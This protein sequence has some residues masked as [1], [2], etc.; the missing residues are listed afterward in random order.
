MGHHLEGPQVR[1]IVCQ[2]STL[3]GTVIVLHWPGMTGKCQSLVV[4]Q[5]VW[6]VLSKF[7]CEEALQGED[8]SQFWSNFI[9]NGSE[10]ED[11]KLKN[12]SVALYWQTNRRTSGSTSPGQEVQQGELR[13]GTCEAAC[14][15][16]MVTGFLWPQRAK[17]VL[18]LPAIDWRVPPAL[19]K[20][21]RCSNWAQRLW[22]CGPQ[23]RRLLCHLNWLWGF[24]FVPMLVFT[25]FRVLPAP[26]ERKP[27]SEPGDGENQY[28]SR[29]SPHCPWINKAWWG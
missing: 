28:F 2:S 8:V 18:A 17:V 12:T 24:W 26:F 19:W 27:A 20:G 14:V 6:I 5:P 29:C 16:C 9:M 4:A 22:A 1:G 7:Y 13:S 3:F 10:V 11:Q 21:L 23:G 25:P 15:D